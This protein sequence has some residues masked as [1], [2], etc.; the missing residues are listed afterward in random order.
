VEDQWRMRV[1]VVGLGRVPV[2]TPHSEEDDTPET[3]HNIQVVVLLHTVVLH[4]EGTMTDE[5]NEVPTEAHDDTVAQDVGRDAWLGLGV[6]HTPGEEMTL[7]LA[8]R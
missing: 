3:A 1:G 5:D 7:I 6:D 4:T 8:L 2:G